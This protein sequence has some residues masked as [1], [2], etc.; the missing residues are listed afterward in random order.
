MKTKLSLHASRI[1]ASFLAV[2]FALAPATP[3]QSDASTDAKQKWAVAQ[4]DDELRVL[5]S[6]EIGP[7]K[8]QLD[9]DWKAAV[10]EY[11]G[12]R[13]FAAKNN[14]EFT[15]E[16][17]ARPKLKVIKNG[18]ATRDAAEAALAAWQAKSSKTSYAV[19]RVGDEHRV[20]EAS[21]VKGLKKEVA[22]LDKQALKDYEAA[23][24][25]AKKAK[26]P[27]DEKKPTKTT[28]KV[29]KKFPSKEAAQEYAGTFDS[30]EGEPG[31]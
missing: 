6:A 17:P 25:A 9:A 5:P 15:A 3:S 4:V 10:K 26:Q 31:E 27:F 21:L 24:K 28:V 29:L 13:K 11:E 14:Q 19:V 1:A 7:L 18:L 20:V 30:G 23:K 12:Q 2:L 8:K 22:L 16:K